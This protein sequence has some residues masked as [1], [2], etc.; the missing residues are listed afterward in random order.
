[1]SQRLHTRRG[2]STLTDATAAIAELAAQIVQPG[3]RLATV[4]VSPHYDSEAL[5]RALQDHFPC[6]VLAC[7]TAGEI[8]S[9]V[10]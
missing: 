6:P 9:D 4:F 2:S 3:M 7:T 8:G 10:G 5:G 1:M